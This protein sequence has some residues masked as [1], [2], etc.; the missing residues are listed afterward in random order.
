MGVWCVY[1]VVCARTWPCLCAGAAQGCV[2]CGGVWVVV[3]CVGSGASVGSGIVRSVCIVEGLGQGRV[4]G[5]AVGVEGGV[6]GGVR[7]V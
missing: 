6:V 1:G 5:G 7:A 2:E 4:G 3:G